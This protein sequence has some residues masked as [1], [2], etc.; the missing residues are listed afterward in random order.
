MQSASGAILGWGFRFRDP[1]NN[2][3]IRRL[4][5]TNTRS[6]DEDAPCQP[7]GGETP[8]LDDQERCWIEYGDF[9]IEYDAETAEGPGGGRFDVRIDDYV[10]PRDEDEDPVLRLDPRR[11]GGRR[12]VAVDEAGVFGPS[13]V[14]SQTADG[15]NGG[16]NGGNT[17]VPQSW[18]ED[19]G[20]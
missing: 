7:L 1:N 18:A 10:F 19:G 11:N 8:A 5:I 13:I 20:W 4:Y 14:P 16:Q 17:H 15:A 9:K 12:V 2:G 6:R 3:T